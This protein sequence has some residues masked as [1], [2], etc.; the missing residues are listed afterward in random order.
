MVVQEHKK[1]KATYKDSVSL[2]I[3]TSAL[4]P[5]SAQTSGGIAEGIFVSVLQRQWNNKRLG[6]RE[7]ILAYFLCFTVGSKK[8]KTWKSG[9]HEMY[10]GP[11]SP[12]FF[13]LV[14]RNSLT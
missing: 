13:S 1:I 9:Q 8:V 14:V 10:T 11:G 2:L 5:T 3:S 7:A 6:N 4:G 12:V